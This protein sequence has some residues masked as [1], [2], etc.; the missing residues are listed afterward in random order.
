M[1]HAWRQIFEV[2]SANGYSVIFGIDVQIY[3]RPSYMQFAYSLVECSTLLWWYRHAKASKKSARKKAVDDFFWTPVC[4]CKSTRRHIPWVI[5]SLSL[6]WQHRAVPDVQFDF[7]RW[8]YYVI[9]V[10][11][12]LGWQK[13]LK[14]CMWTLIT[15]LLNLKGNLR[16]EHRPIKH[17][18]L[19]VK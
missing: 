2:L 16:Q 17:P 11:Y 5:P 14:K 13:D 10:I 9:L 8:R 1:E 4:L 18:L 6:L 3:C 12:T 7:L 15:P 19:F